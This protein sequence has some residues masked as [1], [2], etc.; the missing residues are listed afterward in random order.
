L[1]ESTFERVLKKGYLQVAMTK[2]DRPPF[3]MKNEHGELI[4][5][6][7]EIAKSMA[8]KLGVAVK[9]NRDATSFD[10]VIDIVAK[11]DADIGISKLSYTLERAKLVLYSNPYIKLRKALLINRIQYAKIRAKRKATT[12]YELASLK[13]F[14]VGVVSKSSYVNFA[15]TLFPNSEIKPFRLWEEE[16]LKGVSKGKLLAAFRDELEI[17]KFLLLEPNANL[18]V[19]AII[20]KDQ[21]DPIQMV[22]KADDNHFKDWVNGF[23]STAKIELSVDGILNKYK[24]YLN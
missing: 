21:D 20:L 8:E 5:V 19:L 12:L 6:D 18:H 9:F 10:G 7:V 24:S 2:L 23:L 22:I 1:A 3:F 4:G 15:N 11:G 16:I 14:T 17:K 13:D